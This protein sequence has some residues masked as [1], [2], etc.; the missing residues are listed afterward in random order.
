MKEVTNIHCRCVLP[1]TEQAY[2]GN[3]ALA[4]DWIYTTYPELVDEQ[5]RQAIDDD[6]SAKRSV[7]QAPS[8]ITLDMCLE[9]FGHAEQLTADNAWYE[10]IID[11][12]MI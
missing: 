10:N 12:F 5:E 4:F 8:V 6:T 1:D 9:L 3:G 2:S 11:D 7:A